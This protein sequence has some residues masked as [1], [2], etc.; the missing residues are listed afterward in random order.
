MTSLYMG[1]SY[2]YVDMIE[3]KERKIPEGI[4]HFHVNS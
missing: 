3:D 4:K 1:E 2:K